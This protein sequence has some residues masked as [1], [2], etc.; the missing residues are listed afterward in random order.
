MRRLKTLFREIDDRT[1]T[2]SEVLLSLRMHKGLVPHNEVSNIPITSEAL[3]GFKRCRPGQLVMNRMRAAI[4][5]FGIAHQL[6]LVSPDYAVFGPRE[7]VDEEF[8]L[9][10]LR[11]PQCER[12]FGSNLRDSAQALPAS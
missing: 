12:C 9:N 3:I 11:T 4:G 6:G 10:L 8:I 7:L 5:M 1:D 2:G